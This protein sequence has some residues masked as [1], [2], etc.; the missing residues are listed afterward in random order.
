MCSEA[1]YKEMMAVLKTDL[2]AS[3]RI[4]GTR[5]QAAALLKIIEGWWKVNIYYLVQVTWDH[6]DIF[7]LIKVT[8][9]QLECL[10]HQK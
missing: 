9:K 5:S 2:P 4:T 1:E 7:S 8:V 3:F 6:L 10:N